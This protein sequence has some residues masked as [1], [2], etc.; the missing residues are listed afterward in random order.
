MM[1]KVIIQL[2]DGL[3]YDMRELHPELTD[4]YAAYTYEVDEETYARWISVL[5]AF[6]DLQ[7]E[8]EEYSK[9]N[10]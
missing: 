5:D 1:R 9:K 8:L 4:Y 7:D 10:S 2:D 6:A 3:A